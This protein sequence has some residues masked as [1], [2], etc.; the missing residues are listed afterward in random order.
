V[1]IIKNPL[2]GSGTKNQVS[3]ITRHGGMIWYETAQG[4][5]ANFVIELPLASPEIE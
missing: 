2:F 1:K 4:G 3:S 5:G